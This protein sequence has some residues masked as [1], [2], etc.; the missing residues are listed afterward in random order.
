M[1]AI[2]PIFLHIFKNKS[3]CYIKTMDKF[4]TN[5][6]GDFFGAITASIIAF[7][8]ALAFGV[9]SGLGAS[10]GLWGA[11]ILSLFTGI[12]G[13]NIPIVSGPTGPSSIII[14]TIILSMN[15]DIKSTI[16]VLFFAAILQIIIS[17]T[18]IPK[19]IKY[20]PYP[21]I[22]GFLTGIGLIII[23][24]QI[25]PLLGGKIYAST[26][27]AIKNYPQIFSNIDIN[28]TILGISTLIILFFMPKI[29]TRFLP[30]QLIALVLMTLI[31][32]ILNLNIE[33][34]SSVSFSLPMLQMPNISFNLMSTTLTLAL[35]LAFISSS[36]SL[37][38]GIIVDSL[39]KTKHN[40]KN[41][42]LMQGLGNIFC[43]LTGSM[44]GAA[45]TMRSVAA[46][47][48]GSTTKLTQIFSAIILIFV[49]LKFNDFI[50]QIPICVL[51]AILIKIGYDILDLKVLKILK[52]APKDDLFVLLTVLFL[53]VF[54]NLVSALG[55]GVVLASLLYAKR[56]ADNTNIKNKN[57][58]HNYT[59][60]EI[61]TE[62]DSRY[63]IRILHIDGQFFFGSISQ[64]VSHFDELLET[65]FVILTYSS[66][67]LLDMSAIFALE[68]III[69]L[70]AQ[71]IKLYLVLEND[72][73]YNQIKSMDEVVN[74]I[75]KESIFNNENEAIKLAKNNLK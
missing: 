29:I 8:Q 42:V 54:Y 16:F 62:K 59:N 65:K 9:A 25:S 4:K 35:T 22:S 74:Y 51:A 15:N 14:A 11:I 48:N 19:F 47:K 72:E 58:F 46:I 57:K 63:K 64:I 13:G 68:D 55:I 50:S 61:K 6:K 43:A 75:D 7:P 3:L 12:F 36:E 71:K 5:L 28:S 24:L 10:A 44:N 32:S 27:E 30:S 69:R 37:L 38:T 40:S 39:T 26:I 60:D 23:I 33:K 49:L 1:G 66:N 21:V 53:T 67:S 17:L 73:V 45:A 31:S 70:K 2:A 41:L 18:S 56:L 34:I 20:V 52:H